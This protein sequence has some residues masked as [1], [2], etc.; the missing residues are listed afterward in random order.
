MAFQKVVNT[1][2]VAVIYTQN[3]ETISTSFGAEKAGGY[4]LAAV[5]SLADQVDLLV[6]SELLPTQ[7]QDCIY[8][9][10]EVRGLAVENDLFATSVVSTGQGILAVEGLPN[11]VTLSLKKAS[12]F[13]G[14]SARGRWYYIGLTSTSLQSNENKWSQGTIDGAV[15]AL[16]GLRVGVLTG[17]WVPVIVSRFNN[18]LQ[19]D[20]GVTFD[21]ID[22]VAVDV[23]VDSQRG[24]LTR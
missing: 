11:N 16:E 24:R 1:A 2:E 13:T 20:E 18:K 6:F 17:P 22:T 12:G 10:T 7:S 15:A 9:R 14:R 3:G 4:D 21:W 23:N 8:Q 5:Q 19:R